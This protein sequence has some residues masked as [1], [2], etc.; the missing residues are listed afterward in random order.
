V[1]AFRETP[2][3]ER[4]AGEA[5]HTYVRHYADRAYKI[6]NGIIKGPLVQKGSRQRLAIHFVY[7]DPS[8][9]VYG[10]VVTVEL[11]KFHQ[12]VPW[13]VTGLVHTN[14]VS[15]GRYIAH[16]YR[17]EKDR[18]NRLYFVPEGAGVRSMTKLMGVDAGQLE[19][20]IRGLRKTSCDPIFPG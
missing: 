9:D 19:T 18:E 12:M 10:Q 7:G 17:P 16:R 6:Y 14:L 20:I 3:S 1:V 8:K 5:F 11:E 4:V 15:G 2:E 13:Y